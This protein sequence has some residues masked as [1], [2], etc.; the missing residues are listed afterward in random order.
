MGQRSSGKLRYGYK[1]KVDLE[2]IVNAIASKL[3]GDLYDWELDG[4]ELI[5]E[6]SH[7]THYSAW[8][9]R[10]TLESPEENEVECDEM[11]DESDVAYAVE[12]AL[13]SMKREEI[14]TDLDVDDESDWDFGEPY[15]P[16]YDDNDAYDR[17]RDAKY[18]EDYARCE[19]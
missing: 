11:I 7:E 16:R 1:V 4:S 19:E 8:Y 15:D 3:Y 9:C 12:E 2:S 17:W 18:D 10:A 6:M 13:H 14:K 5:M